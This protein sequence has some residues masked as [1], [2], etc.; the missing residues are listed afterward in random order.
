MQTKKLDTPRFESIPQLTRSGNYAVHVPWRYLD[1]WCSDFPKDLDPEFQRVHVWNRNQQ[2]RYVEF[3]LRGG[4]SSKDL[5]W[6]CR[7]WMKH[8]MGEHPLILVDGKQRLRAVN[9]FLNN[10]IKAFGYYLRQFEDKLPMD[11]DFIMHVNDLETY[12]EVLEWYIDLNSGGVAHTS[13][14]INKVKGILD[15]VRKRNQ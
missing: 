8:A 6:N 2:S 4:K 7:G 1:G 9:L 11:A 15:C 12:E 3:V 10:K 13:A 14:E 5:Y